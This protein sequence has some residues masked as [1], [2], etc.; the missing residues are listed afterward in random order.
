MSTIIRSAIFAAAVSAGLFAVQSRAFA[1][2]DSARPLTS[3]DLNDSHES[4]QFWDQLQR[5]GN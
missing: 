4:K 5:R 2:E 3:Y 1:L